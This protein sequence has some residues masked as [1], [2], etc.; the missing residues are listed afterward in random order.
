MPDGIGTFVLGLAVISLGVAGAFAAAELI[1][2]EADTYLLVW[3]PALLL[4][5]I[6]AGVVVF[7]NETL[8]RP[9][10]AG[11]HDPS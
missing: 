10:A 6:A 5:A 11:P 4:A 7:R 1:P 2:K 8:E 9:R 3:A